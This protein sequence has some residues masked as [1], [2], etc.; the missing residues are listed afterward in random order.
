MYWHDKKRELRYLPEGEEFVIKNGKKRFTRAIYGLNSSFRFETSDFPEFGLYMPRLGGSIYM[1]VAASGK[2]VWIKDLKSVESRFKSGQRTYIL[3][4]KNLL[5]D[6]VLTIDAV[7]LSDGD[8]IIAKFSGRNIP[9]DT[10]VFWIYG[11]A[12]DQRFSR[13]GDLGVDPK[14]SFFIKAENCE[15]NAYEISDHTFALCYASERRIKGVFPV[16]TSIKEADGNAVNSLVDLLKSEKSSRPVIIA[17]YT[18]TDKSFYFEM[19]NPASRNDF[20][21]DDLSK[22]FDDGVAARDKIASRM[23]LNTPDPFINTLGGIFAGAENAAWEHPGYLHGAIGWRA[24]LTGWRAAYLG[25]LLGLHERARIHF[26]GYVNSQVTHVPVTKPHLQDAEKNLARPAKEWGTP[27]YSDGYICRSPNK[28]DVMHHYDMNLVFIDE[29]LWH[30]NWTGDM[31]YARAIY[32]VFERHLAWEKNTFDPDNDGLYDAVCC[33]WAS[34]A[35]QYNG[36]KVTHSSAYNYRANKMMAEIAAKLGKDPS[37]YEKEAALILSALNRELWIN[38]KGWWAE[39]KDNIGNQLRHDS[40][41]VWSVYHPIDAGIH[42]SFKA[43]Q[44]TRYID[45]EIPHIPVAESNYVVSTT[46]WQPYMWSIN[47]VAFAEITHTALAYWQTGRC[48]EA[49]KLF[50]GAILDSM[51]LG[52]GSGNITQTSFYDAVRGETYRDFSDTTATGVRALVLGMYGIIPD[53]MNDKLLI[54]PGFPE[55]W[56]FA[57]IETQNMKYSFRR[58]GATDQYRITP[59]LRKKNLALTMEVKAALDQ[60]KSILV[61]GKE[62]PYTLVEDA[63][64]APMIKFE[65]GIADEYDIEIKWEGNKINRDA[66]SVNVVNGESLTLPCLSGEIYDPQGVL[67][68]AEFK[69]GM[70][71]GRITALN[72]HRTVF[73]KVHSGDMSYWLPLDINVVNPVELINDPESS[74]LV[75]ELANNTGKELKGKLFLNGAEVK[76][77]VSIAAHGKERFQFEAATLGTNIVELKT[78]HAIYTMKAINWN[79]NSPENSEYR[80][81]DMDDFF[82][83]KVRDIFG[84]GKYVSPRWKYTTLQIPSQGM[85]EWC[86]PMDLSAIDDRGVREKAGSQNT[87]TMP[88][89]IP[90]ATPGGAENNNILFTTLWDNYP[91]SADIPLHGKASKAYFLVAGYTYHM[92]AHILNGRIRVKYRDGSEDVLELTLPENLIPL[93]RDVFIDGWAFTSK[94]P[95]PWRVRLKTGEVDK[96]HTGKL[97]KPFVSNCP[98][99]VDGGMATMLDL[100]LNPAKEL[101]SL[102]LETVANEVIIGLMSITLV[103]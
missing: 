83:D 60:V 43:Y 28:T 14:D 86:H 9:A 70:L 103:K 78:D 23:K 59:N 77:E 21:Y 94:D 41:A 10:K 42:D 57:E 20:K 29:L 75:F 102:T 33:I 4:D 88:Q 19:H 62:T 1:A 39:F 12:N 64:S 24:P 35:L 49:F 87:F 63:I 40:A 38:D 15:G 81:V 25:D 68:N 66:V 96:Y 3:K 97:R 47:N 37:V 90:F 72:G 91:T 53:L 74:S 61:N 7:V 27:M 22:C 99:I 17:E 100:P 34:D 56:N 31:D 16:G 89:G 80:T 73:V 2:T 98:A 30:L 69:D 101:A 76:H 51:Y 50:K 93:D 54:K 95:R 18:V 32:P 6:G 79:L 44:A 92:Q 46:N 5:G 26:D 67:S 71:T 55:S 8:G 45:T 52:S 36:G 11:G 84:Y 58:D 85:G 82:N 48:E 65:A 13:E